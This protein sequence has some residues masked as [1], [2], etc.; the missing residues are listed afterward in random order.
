MRVHRS[1]GLVLLAV[2]TLVGER[3]A[4]GQETLSTEGLSAL[5]KF[6]DPP[7]GFS[8]YY[9]ADWVRREPNEQETKLLLVSPAGYRCWVIVINNPK[10]TS[11]NAKQIVRYLINNGKIVEDELKR[12]F[13]EA[14]VAEV[15]PV[16]LS[17]Y[18]SALFS[19][20]YR[21]RTVG[22]DAIIGVLETH[23]PI[24]GFTYKVGCSTVM[25]DSG[26]ADEFKSA[27]AVF[28]R[29]FMIIPRRG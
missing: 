14:Y 6:V 8:V 4:S 28:F 1:A 29:S 16:L 13:A 18:D 11:E 3:F 2:L 22:I 12:R 23:T 20:S 5:N 17:N 26:L 27:A 7:N 10:S 21:Y 9:G 24:K 19:Y 15:R 25:S